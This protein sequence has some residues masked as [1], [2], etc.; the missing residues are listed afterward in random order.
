MIEPMLLP[1]SETFEVSLNPLVW[2]YNSKRGLSAPVN[3]EKIDEIARTYR[4]DDWRYRVFKLL[5][6][7]VHVTEATKAH[8]KKLDVSRES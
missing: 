4:N 5:A 8:I 7:P 2:S 3:R 1:F 6:S